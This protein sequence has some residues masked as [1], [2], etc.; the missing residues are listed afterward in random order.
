M[1]RQTLFGVLL[2]VGALS[3]L[4][5]PM[6]YNLLGYK[7]P[8]QVTSEEST[9][10]VV[11]EMPVES[12]ETVVEQ[13]SEK[14]P[15]EEISSLAQAEEKIASPEERDPDTIAIS[16]GV[17][18]LAFS[19]K[20]AR[21]ISAHALEYEYRDD[22]PSSG[23]VSLIDTARGGI[24]ALRIGGADTDSLLFSYDTAASTE[25]H[26]VFRAPYEDSELVKTYHIPENSY[27]IELSVESRALAGN[28]VALRFDSGMNEPEDPDNMSTRLVPREYFLSDSRGNISVEKERRETQ[29]EFSGMYRWVGTKSKYFAAA[30]IYPEEKNLIVT[31][32]SYAVD[33]SLAV[34]GNNINYSLTVESGIDDI[35][36]EY[37]LFLGP[38]QVDL[39]REAGVGLDRMVFRG[40]S[41]LWL[42]TI[43]PALCNF[44]LAVMTAVY[45]VLGD[46]G[47]GIL[48]ITILMKL[49]TFPLTQSSL[50]SM[51]QMKEIQPKIR[52]I[53]KKYKKDP[54]VMQAKMMEFY[55]KEGVSPLAGLGGCLPMFIQMPIMLSLFVVP[56]KAIELRGEQTLLVP[57]AADLSQPEVLFSLPM[58]L[59]LY[60]GHVSL[61]P[62]LA[63]LLMFFQ[64]K[65]TITDPQQKSM[66]YIMPFF[67]AVMF[68][69]FPAGLT[70]YFLFSTIFQL[71]QQKLVNRSAA[72]TA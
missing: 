1:N 58:T 8:S 71:L 37:T 33:P 65:D 27:Y 6:W 32:Q 39:L 34:D 51:K 31:A 61:L 15:E 70:L 45:S 13:S 66:M 41:F 29:Q 17:L 69:N 63:A 46:Y 24:G 19:E 10:S 36:H 67:M 57:W 50:K 35:S 53:Q 47:L 14:E 22:M 72:P 23:V 44:V 59:P 43:F 26:A 4:N 52:E 9:S 5:S 20:G 16:N 42:D 7:H 18:D 3:F 49:I 60:G 54:Q 25:T 62:I 48:A 12:S 2:V 64:N 28:N 55:Q 21:I 38:A 68:N 40:W 11:Q 56:R 30:V